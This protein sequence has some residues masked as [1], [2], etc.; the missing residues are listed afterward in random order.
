MAAKAGQ[1]L[2]V[3][4]LLTYGADPRAVDSKGNTPA[5]CAKLVNVLFFVEN[6]L[7]VYL[8]RLAGHKDI[9]ERLND[10]MYEVLDVLSMYV[11]ERK[12]V[13]KNGEHLINFDQYNNS[14]QDGDQQDAVKKMQQVN[15]A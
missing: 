12:A 4:L 15:F 14:V 7:L 3:E 1:I 8:S 10:S 2:Q 6:K 13:H 5:M 9:N 11:F